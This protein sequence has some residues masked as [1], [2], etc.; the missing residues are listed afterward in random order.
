MLKN[1]YSQNSSFLHVVNPTIKLLGLIS[2]L[3]IVVSFNRYDFSALLPLLAVPIFL[4]VIL[5]IPTLSLVKKSLPACFLA[6]MAAFANLFLDRECALKIFYLEISYG[7]ISFASLILKAFLCVSSAICFSR[8][9]N[10]A[11]IAYALSSLKIPC[12][13]VLQILLTSRYL[14]TITK[15]AMRS[16]RAYALRSPTHPK[17]RAKHVPNILLSLLLRSL[18]RATRIY[19]A[20]QIRGFSIISFRTKKL[21]QNFRNRFCNRQSRQRSTIF[22]HTFGNLFQSRRRSQTLK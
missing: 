20:M 5:N 4:S 2:F 18:D 6:A 7:T 11:D 15:E 13:I 22:K 3:L 16:S 8:C 17:I 10:T 12:V 14:E 1:S 21:R 19:K 9:T